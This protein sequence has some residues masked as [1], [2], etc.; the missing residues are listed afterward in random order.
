MDINILKNRYFTKNTVTLKSEAGVEG[1]IVLPESCADIEKIIKCSIMPRIMGKSIEGERLE[2]RGTAFLRLSYL[3]ENCKLCSFETQI[4]FSK[5][6]TVGSFE[7]PS[8][9][10]AAQCDY[11]NCRPISS[12]RF[13]VRSALNLCISISSKTPFEV[14]GNIEGAEYL[15][16]NR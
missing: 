9:S 6:V 10:V 2:I 15:Y 12:R 14:I 7:N 11:I 4:P 8:V 13:E 5:S 1:D 16:R 3:S